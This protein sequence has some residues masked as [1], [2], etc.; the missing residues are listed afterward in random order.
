MKGTTN[1]RPPTARRRRSPVRCARLARMVGRDAPDMDLTGWLN[2]ARWF[3]EQQ[4][5]MVH[6]AAFR[7]ASNVAGQAPVDRRRNWTLADQAAWPNA[8]SG[9]FVDFSDIIPADDAVRNDASNAAPA[10]AVAL[11]AGA[12]E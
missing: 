10:V 12:R 7:V 4:L 1:T 11:L 6:D 8:W 2:L 9:D 3:S 5:R